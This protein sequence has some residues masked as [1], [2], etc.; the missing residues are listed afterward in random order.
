MIAVTTLI[1]ALPQVE[2]VLFGL[3]SYVFEPSKVLQAK[4]TSQQP[5]VL[6]DVTAGEFRDFLA[7]LIAPLP[8]SQASMQRDEADD[9]EYVPQVLVLLRRW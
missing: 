1:L 7:C 6:E 2:G 3:P 9:P 5:C 8:P 4:I